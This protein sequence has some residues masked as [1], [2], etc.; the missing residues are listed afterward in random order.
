MVEWAEA[1]IARSHDRKAF[2]CGNEAL[3][4][5]LREHARQSH[6]VGGAKTFVAAPV[7]DAAR[8]LGFYSLSPTSLVYAQTP[9]IARKGLARH[10]VPMFRLARLAVDLSVQGRGLGG[11]LLIAA[12]KRC[13]AVAQEV[14]GVGLYIDA[15]D[16]AADNWY[17]GYGAVPLLDNP[18]GL[19]LSFV[20]LKESLEA[21]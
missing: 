11:G 18:L 10:D 16:E 12:G 20:T 19:V 4:R 14:G 2:D 13:M 7:D 5:F 1:P 6:R 15:K 3:N 8:I 17:R 21:G 9:A